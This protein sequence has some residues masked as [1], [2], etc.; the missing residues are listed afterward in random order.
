M[1]C[2]SVSRFLFPTFILAGL[3]EKAWA[4]GGNGIR[5]K[6]YALGNDVAVGGKRAGMGRKSAGRDGRAEGRR[7]V[8][9]DV[10]QLGEQAV[11]VG[12]VGLDIGAVLEA[13]DGFFL[14]VVQLFGDIYHYVD[15]FVAL[16]AV[17]VDAFAA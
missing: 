15:K 4:R 17:G 12:F 13:F 8:A 14:G 10:F 3:M 9:E 1:F 6:L 11:L 7:S 5:I 16:A 2:A